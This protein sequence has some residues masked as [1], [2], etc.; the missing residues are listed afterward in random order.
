MCALSP[1]MRK[2]IFRAQFF[3]K[4][5]D[6]LDGIDMNDVNEEKKQRAISAL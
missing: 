3:A 5:D 1:D 2:A 6:E 4:V